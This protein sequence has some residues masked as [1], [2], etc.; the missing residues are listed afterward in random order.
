LNGQ[1]MFSSQ[2]V[3]DDLLESAKEILNWSWECVC[4]SCHIVDCVGELHK[5]ND[6][7]FSESQVA[8][9][10]HISIL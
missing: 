7:G 4:A 9:A 5:K 6:S 8:I 3:A 10:V 2:Q 1:F